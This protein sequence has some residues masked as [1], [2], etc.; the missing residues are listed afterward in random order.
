MD[1]ISISDTAPSVRSRVSEAEWQ[2]RVDLAAC[3]RLIAHYG[4]TDLVYN[5]ITAKIPGRPGCFLINPF[6]LLYTEMT[7]SCF[8]TLD[9]EGDIVDRPPGVFG[10]FPVNR[11]GYALHSAVHGGRS[12]V[13]CVIHTHTRAGMAVS[14]LKQGILPLTQTSMRF[15]GAIGFHDYE[16]PTVNAEER[17]RIVAD[18]GP[19]NALILRNHGLLA[20]GETIPDAWNVIYW[21]ESSCKVQMDVLAS[22]CEI[23]LPPAELAASMAKRYGPQGKVNLAPIEWPALLRQMDRVDPSFRA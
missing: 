4:M 23:N 9:L 18:L 14:A 5:H 12:D 2:V 19:H 3:Y 1:R 15:F 21:L 20:C 8:Y 6:G 13:G 17:G 10:E 11:A 22:G 16:E 7:A